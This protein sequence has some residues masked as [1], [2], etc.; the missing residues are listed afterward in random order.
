M[1]FLIGL[2]I[3]CGHGGN[4]KTDSAEITDLMSGTM[5]PPDIASE[6]TTIEYITNEGISVDI[7]AIKGQVIIFFDSSVSE[8][9]IEKLIGSNGGIIIA[10]IPL[11]R[12]YLVSITDNVMSFI[13]NIR[14]ENKA[15]L[16]MPNIPIETLHVEPNE[17]K[18]K[19][20]YFSWHLKEINAPLAWEILDDT[21]L[22]SIEIGFVD[23]SFNGLNKVSKDFQG[24]V[25]GEVPSELP[26]PFASEG[27]GTKVVA[28]ASAIGN[29]EFG[30]VGINWKSKIRLERTYSLFDLS[31]HILNLANKGAKVINVSLGVPTCFGMTTFYLKPLFL[32]LYS[33][34][35]LV[36]D[37][38]FL[39]VQAAGNDGCE[40]IL[41]NILK[42]PDNFILVGAT[43]YDGKRLPDSNFGSMIDIVAPGAFSIFYYSTKR[44]ECVAGTSF[45]TP[46]V[47]GTAALIWAKE[48]DLTPQ[49]V[50]QRLK[51]TT[52][53][54]NISEFGEAGI[55]NVYKTLLSKDITNKP[56]SVSNV[57]LSGQGTGEGG[58]GDITITYDLEDADNDNCSITVEYQ[59]GSVGTT[60]TEATI[61]GEISGITPGIAKSFIWLSAMDESGYNA[62]DYKIKITPHDGTDIG[63]AGISPA[64]TVNN[65]PIIN[66]PPTA[67]ITNPSNNSTFTK[68]DKITFAGAGTDTEDGDL[69]GD[70]LIWISDKDGQIGTGTSFSK[71]LS[72]NTHTITLTVTDSNGDL[73]TT[74]ITVIVNT[75][76]IPQSNHPPIVSNIVLS[77]TGIYDGGTGDITITYTL[78]DADNDT[79]DI[80]IEYRYALA[81]DAMSSNP[82]WS[83]AT[84]VEKTFSVAP[85]NRS[86]TWR[87][88]IDQPYYGSFKA[89][90]TPT[91]T[92]TGTAGISDWFEIN[93]NPLLTPNTSPTAIIEKPA[94]NSAFYKGDE[95]EFKGVVGDAEDGFVWSCTW[96]SDVDGE[97][98]SGSSGKESSISCYVL[99][100]ASCILSPGAHTITLTVKDSGGL[101]TT[102]SVVITINDKYET[103]LVERD[104]QILYCQNQKPYPVDP[105]ILEIM[106]NSGLPGWT[107][108]K[109]DYVFK[110]GN[111]AQFIS[112]GILIREVETEP[113]Y[114]VIRNKLRWIR[115]V[116]ALN[117]LNPNGKWEEDIIDVPSDIIFRYEK[118]NDIF[119]LGEGCYEDNADCSIVFLRTYCDYG[120]K[121]YTIAPGGWPGD[122]LTSEILEFPITK[123][124]D[125]LVSGCSGISGKYQTFGNESIELGAIDSSEIGTYI[126]YGA[127]Y[128]KYKE[129]GYSSSKLGFPTSNEYYYWVDDE[130]CR[131]SNFEGGYIYWIPSTDETHVNYFDVTDDII[132]ETGV[133]G[134]I[135]YSDTPLAGIRVALE[136]G[137]IYNEKGQ[138]IGRT[139]IPNTEAYTDEN[140]VYKIL[141]DISG[142][143]WITPA[144]PSPEYIEISDDF[145][146]KEGEL[147]V[148]NF[149]MIKRLEMIS[150]QRGATINDT[151]PTFIWE[152]SPEAADYVLWV[153][154]SHPWEQ[155]LYQENITE[156]SYTITNPLLPDIW[157]V[158]IICGYNTSESYNPLHDVAMSEGMFII[159]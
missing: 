15:T 42:K 58:M 115:S 149:H 98:G 119:A 10:K 57:N 155:V 131:R 114:V 35:I 30:N 95:V 140:G 100:A 139:E 82:S 67:T 66:N 1:L 109:N 31:Y 92:E 2:L 81:E 59:G 127:I 53:G 25:L 19:D 22:N 40:L 102:D 13:S 138:L 77:G 75:P 86:V 45:A 108:Y 73:D 5:P 118:G 11:I 120:D 55:L 71:S 152:A 97:M 125:A 89:R 14:K 51:G 143:Y 128:T 23:K 12:Y 38:N 159:K 88:G 16:V 148:Q 106:V 151:T 79:C 150:P 17:W 126:V 49:G 141:Y 27:H 134:A 50:I 123:V 4:S 65:G 145:K 24:R 122:Y 90:I 74:S 54:I 124:E 6:I 29:N 60:W 37:K 121:D 113:V 101:I 107:H 61:T 46:L 144:L 132:L 96:T 111:R 43:G 142:D 91:D 112:D 3:G 137:D 84:T 146:I 133:T 26:W 110:W 63:T 70:S 56:P 78:T 44:I 99:A 41:P 153:Y 103:F 21:I 87:S 18:D 69:I 32:A 158:V 48:P 154:I 104:D 36:P 80:T 136:K 116:E 72:V 28:I 52:K 8:N 135:Y 157:Y 64:F 83:A 129:L 156:T 39:V 147:T 33:A 7:E 20:Y 68:G 9:T 85:G 76:I 94:N 105:E 47:S 34:R 93:N 130:K 62:N 117:W